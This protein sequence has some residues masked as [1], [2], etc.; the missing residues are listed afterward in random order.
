MRSSHNK[1]LMCLLSCLLIG[2]G[3]HRLT[4]PDS[5]SSDHVDQAP[6]K[7]HR[8]KQHVAEASGQ[9]V[10]TIRVY[11]PRSVGTKSLPVVAVYSQNFGLG[12]PRGPQVIVAFWQNGH[13]VWSEDT[14]NGGPPYRSST[15][16]WES[17]RN[18]ID[19]QAR[20][21]VF[22]GAM[23]G[24]GTVPIHGIVFVIAI[25]D[26]ARRLNTS[27][28]KMKFTGLATELRHS[29]VALIP[30]NGDQDDALNFQGTVIVGSDSK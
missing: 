26:G 7:V 10:D 2:C 12:T 4:G 30:E 3:T 20:R 27:S 14:V 17:V 18:V 29:L 24:D 6:D 1:R 8:I 11:M 13:V 28:G 9:D 5:V 25:A 23:Y 22:N 15:I 21:G 16:A 19:A